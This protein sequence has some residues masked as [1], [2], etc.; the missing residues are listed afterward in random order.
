[1]RH[2]ACSA[3]DSALASKL[4]FPADLDDALRSLAEFPDARPVAGGLAL[5]LRR[6]SGEVL[7]ERL[8]AVGHLPQL[9]VVE[10]DSDGWLRVGSSVTLR[11]LELSSVV[12]ASAPLLE[13]AARSVGNPGVR[14]T[15]TVGGNLID[16][17]DHSDLQ[18]AAI[19]LGAHAVWA[20]SPHEVIEEP[21]AAIVDPEWWC[22]HRLL[23]E[24]R[25]PRSQP[26]VRRGWGFRRLQTRGHGD[27]PV[28]TVAAMVTSTGGRWVSRC[29]VAF[30][31]PHLL[32]LSTTVT[33]ALTAW[34]GGIANG[35]RRRSTLKTAVATAVARD[36]GATSFISDVRASGDYRRR[37]LP[38]IVWRA[39]ADA[40]DRAAGHAITDDAQR[41]LD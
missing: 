11:E 34:G 40:M 5:L 6:A 29:H 10:V 20:S 22:Q 25:I 17:P 38:T 30:T 2:V 16:Q 14:A 23:V 9:R 21:L 8:V 35:E 36:M 28:T 39:V 18:A 1:M 27:R 19:A 15:G 37:I 7:P 3:P 33:G 4:L 12:R 24:L 31:T 32:D 41:G 26:P 13:H